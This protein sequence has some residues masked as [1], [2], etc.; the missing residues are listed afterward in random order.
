MSNNNSSVLHDAYSIGLFEK[1]IQE[2]STGTQY[3]LTIIL[4][5]SHTNKK[6]IE[7]FSKSDYC[8]SDNG[9]VNNSTLKKTLSDQNYSNND[10]DGYIADDEIYINLC[11]TSFEIVSLKVHDYSFIVEAN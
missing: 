10:L 6:F 8:G 3:A 5:S 4:M 9:S 11:E 1:L 7:S 2:D